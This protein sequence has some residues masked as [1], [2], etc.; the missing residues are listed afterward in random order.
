M[1]NV[2]SEL[3]ETGVSFRQN[4][5]GETA[6]DIANINGASEE[7]TLT[8]TPSEE[9]IR[10]LL[11]TSAQITPTTTATVPQ[12]SRRS[13]LFHKRFIITVVTWR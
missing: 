10:R 4:N 13:G 6:L 1:L 8:L 9:A 11:A 7:V 3:V 12:A 5:K 2:T